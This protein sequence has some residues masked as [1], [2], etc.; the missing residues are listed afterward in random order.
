MGVNN[1]DKTKNLSSLFVLPN[2]R[3]HYQINQNKDEEP[4]THQMNL[5]THTHYSDGGKP[6]IDYVHEAISQGMQSLGFSDHSPLPFHNPFSIRTEQYPNYCNEI[7]NLKKQFANEISI[8]LGLEIDFIPGMSEDFI[9]LKKTGKLDYV[10]GSVHLVGKGNQQNLWF[11]D[12]PYAATYDEG[13]LKFYSNDIRKAVKAFYDQTNQMIE[14]QEMDVVGHLDKIKMHNQNRYFTE[15]EKWYRELVMETL[16]LIK[17][18]NLIA[19]VNTR[20]IYKKRCDSLFPSTWIIQE[21]HRMQIPV[22]ISSDA[23]QPDELLMLFAEAIDAIK[24]A[25][26]RESMIFTKNGWHSMPI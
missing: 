8:Y 20:G 2:W 5:H 26:Y 25:G 11:T 13:L 1:V 17:E 4:I 18:R 15:D 6:P 7:R 23:H 22:L 10:I 12:G 14:S 21:M 3:L 24:M 16:H 19:E 9:S